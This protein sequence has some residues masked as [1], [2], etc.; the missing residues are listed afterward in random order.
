MPSKQS[1]QTPILQ[2][3]LSEWRPTEIFKSLEKGGV[4]QRAVHNGINRYTDSGSINDRKRNGRPCTARAQRSIK[5]SR[6]E[7]RKNPHR[8]QRDMENSIN[9]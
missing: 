1:Q 7:I 8:T 5:V 2:L 9:A 6:S 3:H 4:K